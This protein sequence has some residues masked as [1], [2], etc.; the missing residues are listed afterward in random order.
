ME[1]RSDCASKVQWLLKP[2]VLLPHINK[3]LFCLRWCQGKRKYRTNPITEGKIY[4]IF[5][6]SL[7][8]PNSPFI[9]ATNF[10][11]LP[12]YSN[13]PYYLFWPKIPNVPFITTS[14]CIPDSIVSFFT[15][16][17]PNV[18]KSFRMCGFFRTKQTDGRTD[19]SEFIGLIY[20]RGI[21]N[22]QKIKT[23]IRN[24]VMHVQHCHSQFNQ[25]NMF[26]GSFKIIPLPL[27]RQPS[28]NSPI[29]LYETIS[30]FN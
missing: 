19:R 11:K 28:I 12:V 13:L 3:A 25:K 29:E 30:P 2:L 7:V 15:L 10:S 23:R 14:P 26:H 1:T 17:L 20:S 22:Q 4:R 24:N 16:L 27:Y 8:I 5:P 18:M 9:K 6:S 21:K